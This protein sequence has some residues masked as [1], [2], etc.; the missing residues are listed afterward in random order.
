MNDKLKISMNDLLE[1]KQQ[2]FRAVNLALQSQANPHFYYN[3]LSSIIVLSEN[4]Q[5]ED[6]I[7]LC[8]NLTQIMR[9]ITDGQTTVTTLGEEIEHVKKYLYCIKI[10]YQSS[11][12]YTLD[13]APEI[14]EIPIP[15]LLI[16]P[17]VENAIKYGTDCTPSWS[18]SITGKK[19]HDKWQIDITDS[20]NGFSEEALLRVSRNIAAASEN[21]GMPKLHINGLGIVNVYLR[22]KSKECYRAV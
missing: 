12:N 13:I 22:W 21:S 4:G 1:S 20:G 17:L 5:N 18:L 16:Q 10:R 19:Y 7:R 2:E 15:K 9:Y 3:T 6:V 11:L 8:R 14:L